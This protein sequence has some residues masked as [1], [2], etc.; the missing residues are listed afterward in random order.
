MGKQ[1]GKM[2]W[3]DNWGSRL[4]L[5]P[6]LLLAGD[7][8]VYSSWTVPEAPREAESSDYSRAVADEVFSLPKYLDQ[9][10]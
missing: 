2:K 6:F 7:C 1:P 4:V 10:F 5:P 9:I 3:Q 8:A